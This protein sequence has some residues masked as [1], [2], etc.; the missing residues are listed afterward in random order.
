MKVH[1]ILFLAIM[2]SVLFPNPAKA[3]G[4]FMAYSMRAAEQHVK[5]RGKTDAQVI[6]LGGITSL[7]GMVYDPR[8]KD[9]QRFALE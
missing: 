5:F 9:L 2:V 8:N 4:P 7:A 6:R 3:Q 1:R